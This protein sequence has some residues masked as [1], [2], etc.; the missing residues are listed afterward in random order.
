MQW[1][2]QAQDLWS[3]EFQGVRRI[4]NFSQPAE[5]GLKTECYIG[6]RLLRRTD[7]L[8]SALNIDIS[9]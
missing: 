1:D 2:S 7:I 9:S 4:P 3:S 6:I 5:T 8:A